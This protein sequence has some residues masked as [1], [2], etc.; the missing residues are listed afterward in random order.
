MAWTV[1]TIHVKPLPLRDPERFA[2][3]TVLRVVDPATRKQ[4]P[5]EG[6]DVRVTSR[7]IERYW[8]RNERAGDV[9][10]SPADE[11]APWADPKPRTKK[12]AK[13]KPEPEAGANQEDDEVTS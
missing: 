2:P 3:G 8:D 11:P 4:I 5:P 7:E 1:Y 12:R 9:E 6:A 13:P 10:V